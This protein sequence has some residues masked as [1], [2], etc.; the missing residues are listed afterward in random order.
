VIDYDVK[1]K[2]LW[3]EEGDREAG[4]LPFMAL[5]CVVRGECGCWVA[6]G[7]LFHNGEQGVAWHPC[8]RH[9][10][11]QPDNPQVKFLDS[12]YDDPQARPVEDVIEEFLMEA[13][14]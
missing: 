4:K 7:T 8:E 11:A 13:Q 6:C 2:G 1:G 3:G 12:L 14:G 5:R 10:V 9:E